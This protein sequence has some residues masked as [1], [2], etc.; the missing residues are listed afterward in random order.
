MPLKQA[1]NSTQYEDIRPATYLDY[2]EKI[3]WLWDW[4][5]ALLLG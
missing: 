3:L 4:N 2:L 1:A 5:E